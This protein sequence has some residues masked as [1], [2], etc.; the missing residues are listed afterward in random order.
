M[1]SG[2]RSTTAV[3]KQR[4]VVALMV[5]LCLLVAMALSDIQLK[6]LDLGSWIHTGSS[7]RDNRI[8]I[9]AVAAVLCHRVN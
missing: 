2:A 7:R 6:K 5:D 9:D 4:R 8:L 1:T 3:S